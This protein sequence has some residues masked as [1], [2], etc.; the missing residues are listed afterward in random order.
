MPY[1]KH[2]PKVQYDVN[3]DGVTQTMTNITKRVRFL[4]YVKTNYVNF[5][6]YDVKSGETPE[7]IANEFYG[8]PELHWVILMANDI[9]DYY[10]DWP[11]S[12]TQFE[13]YV[14]SK[15]DD[16]NGVHHYE[17]TQ[18]SGDTSFTIELPN[19][20]AT[21]LPAAAVPVTNYEYEESIQ[22]NKRRI[23]LIQKRFIGQIKKEFKNKMNG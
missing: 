18:E 6:Y 22:E 10:T 23:R 20:S 9:I 11:M 5:D 7:Y 21:T 12:V 14:Y 17:Y 13:S 19:E 1:F 15:Y 16:V 3:G 4:D 8:D 2:F